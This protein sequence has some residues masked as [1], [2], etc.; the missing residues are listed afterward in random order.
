M[1]KSSKSSKTKKSKSV[2]FDAK[3]S[4]YRKMLRIDRNSLDTELEEQPEIFATV[5]DLAALSRS[6]KDEAKGAIALVEAEVENVIRRR[7]LKEKKTVTDKAI[8][9]KVA[10]DERVLDQQKR[11][12]DLSL[13][14]E[15]LDQLKEAWR[16]RNYMLRELSSLFIAGYYQ[17]HSAGSAGA[18]ADKV[19]TKR[20][21][22]ISARMSERRRSRLEG[23]DDD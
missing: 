10:T 12:L 7:A 3:I 18:K 9:A 6:K 21:E 19:R 20:A 13:Q 23:D 16:Q 22:E 17:S 14:T 15:R 5:S 8:R 4:E 1:R 2:D 11:Y